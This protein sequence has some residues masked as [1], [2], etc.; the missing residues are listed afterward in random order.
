MPVAIGVGAGVLVL[1]L[2]IAAIA[3]GLKLKK[4]NNENEKEPGELVELGG[5]KDGWLIEFENLSIGKELGRGL[6]QVFFLQRNNI[7]LSKHRT[8][9]SG[10]LEHLER[11]TV[12]GEAT[13][14][15]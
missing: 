11:C 4:K 8:L 13:A 3:V 5:G 7:N 1:V 9:W 6:K 14:R 2:V 12:C 10:Q 15:A